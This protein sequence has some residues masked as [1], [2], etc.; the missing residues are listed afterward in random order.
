[1][2]SSGVTEL[3]KAKILTAGANTTVAVYC[4]G[5]YQIYDGLLSTLFGLLGGV[6]LLV[7]YL[8]IRD[9]PDVEDTAPPEAKV[10]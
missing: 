6:V 2:L 5:Y 9:K 10:V 8:G 7:T 4:F 3:T 1:M